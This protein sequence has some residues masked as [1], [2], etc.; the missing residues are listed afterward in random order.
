MK[1]LA[2]IV[3]LAFVLVAALAVFVLDTSIGGPPKCPSCRKP[4]ADMG[5]FRETERDRRIYRCAECGIEEC[6]IERRR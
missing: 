3:F 5:F 6:K 2:F 1:E 4:M